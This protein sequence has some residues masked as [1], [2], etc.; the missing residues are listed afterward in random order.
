V[1]TMTTDNETI[2][3]VPEEFAGSRLDVFLMQSAPAGI[4]RG[5][6][7]KAIKEGK[8][9]VDE[10]QITK[11]SSIVRINQ[12]VRIA[13]DTF[14]AP[15]PPQIIPDNEIPLCVIHE[16]PNLLVV[17][18]QPGIA[19]HAG[20]K[21]EHPT[22]ADALVARYPG[23]SKI[24]ED[25]LRPGIVHRLDKDTSG[26]I[27]VARTPEMYTHLKKEFQARHIHKVYYA[28]VRG[29]MGESE[30]KISLP[31]IRSAR[32][33]MRRTVARK[34]EGK[35]AET[36]FEIAEKFLHYTL[37]KVMPVTGRMHQIRV[38]LSHIGFPIY[39]DAL[40]GK[41]IKDS[42]IPSARRHFLHAAELSLTLPSG[43]EKTFMSPLPGDLQEI[44]DALRI[45]KKRQL[46]Q[47]K[48]KSMRK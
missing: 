9:T 23:L 8:I 45:Q 48:P 7:Q 35:A 20:V 44:L 12:T 22:L 26:L 14:A 17:D 28:L 37:V 33:P 29:A 21:N 46:S 15:T 18:K 43:N 41:Q 34:G 42:S 38:H 32:N 25:P 4:S 5:Q 13:P 10:K 2:I 27:L 3:L 40:Y 31:L 39:G 16:D 47:Q 30:G 11:A 6:I 24:G 19:V 36:Y 1:R